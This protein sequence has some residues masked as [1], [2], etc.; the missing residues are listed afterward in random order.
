MK[1]DARLPVKFKP[2]QL[3]GFRVSGFR[4]VRGSDAIALED[5]RHRSIF[6]GPNNAG[7]S[8]LFRFILQLAEQCAAVAG[9]V[10]GAVHIPS[11]F[12]IHSFW[13]QERAGSLEAVLTFS[14]P[15]LK[16]DEEA[17]AGDAVF[18]RQGVWKLQVVVGPA[19]DLQMAEPTWK[20]YAA[21]LVWHANAWHP[22][23]KL[24]GEP[25]YYVEPNKYEAAGGGGIAA[26]TA[27]AV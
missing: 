6:I 22:S 7:K 25:T 20:F 17:R 11:T 3:L 1:W 26:K 5:F 19:E 13:Q 15:G 23:M 27:N 18:T 9:D 14:S 24:A 10:L 8:T 2:V 4:G 12:S 16:H 21:P